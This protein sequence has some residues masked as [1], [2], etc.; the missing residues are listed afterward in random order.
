MQCMVRVSMMRKYAVGMRCRGHVSTEE[1]TRISTEMHSLL[2]CVKGVEDAVVVVLSMEK[3][4][5]AA[6]TVQER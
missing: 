6:H 1:L 4:E 2:E 5:S 3:V